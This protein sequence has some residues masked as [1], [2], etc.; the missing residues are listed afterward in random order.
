MV[1]GSI[2]GSGVLMLALVFR[3]LGVRKPDLNNGIFAYAKA[4][5]G[6]YVGFNAAFGY[7]PRRVRGQC[8]T[9]C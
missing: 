3:S 8:R 5:F 6:N 9:G 4:G 2:V 7:W 1:V